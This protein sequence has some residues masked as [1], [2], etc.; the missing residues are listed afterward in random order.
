MRIRKVLLLTVVILLTAVTANA[1]S[2][3]SPYAY[4]A[5]NPVKYVDPDGREFIC[6]LAPKWKINGSTLSDARKQEMMA[7]NDRLST[8]MY[9]RDAININNVFE[10][11]AHGAPNGVWDQLAF[12]SNPNNLFKVFDDWSPYLSSKNSNSSTYI[13]YSCNTGKGNNS[14]AQKFSGI[15]EVAGSLVIAPTGPVSIDQEGNEYVTN[16]GNWNIFYKGKQVGTISGEK[17]A[18]TKFVRENLSGHRLEEYLKQ[19]KSIEY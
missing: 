2:W 9:K 15:K 3:I 6:K 12:V 16:S 1:Y 5:W 17:G 13:F 19:C 18:M 14:I 11:Y 4:C 7:T 8:N 10:L